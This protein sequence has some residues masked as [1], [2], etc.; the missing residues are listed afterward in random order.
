ML[1]LCL[2]SCISSW[3]FGNIITYSD[4]I[5]PNVNYTAISEE[6]TRS[7]SPG[8]NN[9]LPAFGQPVGGD[10]LSFPFLQSFY[11]ES[12]F[13]GNADTC[14]SNLKMTISAKSGVSGISMITFSEA[15]DYKLLRTDLSSNPVAQVDATGFLLITE[16]NGSPITPISIQPSFDHQYNLTDGNLATNP[17]LTPWS[18][19]L[20]F[21][22]NQALA[23]HGITG[24]ATQAYLSLDDSLLSTSDAD[25]Y[26][27]IRKKQ[28]SLTTTTVSVPEPGVWAMLAITALGLGIWR[29]KN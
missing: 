16:V 2:L 3:A 28:V 19:T 14:D 21:D 11:T 25:S 26:S 1:S 13:G 4:V 24:Y 18:G 5:G 12:P 10:S 20:V 6:P 29:R 7:T 17:L 23:Q 27:Y 8:P 9:P 22:V 15:G